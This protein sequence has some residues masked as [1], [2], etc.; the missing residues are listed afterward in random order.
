MNFTTDSRFDF[1]RK[2]VDAINSDHYTSVLDLFER[3]CS[4]FAE[5]IAFSCLGQDISFRQ[6]DE[7]SGK[8]AAYLRG[9]AGLQHGDRVAIQ[10]PNLIQYPVAA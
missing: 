7:M 6:I 1:S 9:A 4:E 10:L 5:K 8:F 3:A 2:Q